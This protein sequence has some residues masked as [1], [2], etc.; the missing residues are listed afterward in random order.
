[1]PL[2]FPVPPLAAG[3]VPVTPVVSGKPVAFVSVTDVGVPKTGV[4]NVGLVDKTLLPEPVDVV[5]PVP[6]LATGKVPDTC[7]VKLTPLNAPPRVR[8]PELVTVPVR[9]IPLTVP[10]PPTE[11]TEPPPEPAPIAVRNA[12]AD[13]DETV[14]SAL[15]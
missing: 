6:P 8:L 2:A 7:V 3:R 10:V 12:E 4:T 11:T 1:M 14:L 5:T 13:S 15:N 9:V